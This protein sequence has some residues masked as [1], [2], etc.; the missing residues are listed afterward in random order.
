VPRETLSLL[1]ILAKN[2]TEPK[3]VRNQGDFPALLIFNGLWPSSLQGCIRG[4]S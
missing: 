2:Q 3:P 1:A 4:V